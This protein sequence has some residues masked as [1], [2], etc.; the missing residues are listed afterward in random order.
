[1]DTGLNVCGRVACPMGTCTMQCFSIAAP[2]RACKKGYPGVLCSV[3]STMMARM[4]GCIGCTDCSLDS[5]RRDR[6]FI[7]C[8]HCLVLGILAFAFSGG[9]LAQERR[10]WL[11]DPFEQISSGWPGC[12][13]PAGPLWT[14]AEARAEAIAGLKEGRTAGVAALVAAMADSKHPAGQ[15]AADAATFCG[16]GRSRSGE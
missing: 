9:G 11:G 14:E 8:W 5:M 7:M 16:P 1:M 2:M 13:Q 12:P 15:D 3:R 6:T 4:P 10:N